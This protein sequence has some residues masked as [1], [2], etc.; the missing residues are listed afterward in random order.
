MAWNPGTIQGLLANEQ[1]KLG[2]V[3]P[4]PFRGLLAGVQQ[5]QAAVDLENPA[6]VNITNADETSQT[7]KSSPGRLYKLRVENLTA[8]IVFVI[9]ADGVIAQVIGAVKAEAR[10]SASVPSVAEVTFFADPKSVGEAFATS[11]L[12]R[13][14]KLDGTG[15]TGAA[16][17]VSVQAL[18][19]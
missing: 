15:S 1:Y 2:R 8:D 17:G 9:V 6:V 18:V 10:I 11:L 19:G 13:A 4:E 14:F 16:D 3:G 12:V 5:M 7:I